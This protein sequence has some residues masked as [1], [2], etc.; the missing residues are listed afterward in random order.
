MENIQVKM[1][2]LFAHSCYAYCIS[3]MSGK[4]DI[5]DLTTD[6]LEGWKANDFDND[7]Y[8]RFPLKYIERIAGIKYKDVK[9]VPI[10]KISDIPSEPTIVEMQQPNGK[11][12]HFVVC[13]FDG[14]KVILDFDPSGISNSWTRQKFISYRKFTN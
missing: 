2:E 1:Q 4:R 12:S 11:D 3:Y 6:V 7:G 9:K 5:K 8:V 10:S 13:H 14:K